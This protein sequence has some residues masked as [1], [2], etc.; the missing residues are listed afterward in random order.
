MSKYY[1]NKR[2]LLSVSSCGI[3]KK[4]EL[5]DLKFSGNKLMETNYFSSNIL[6]EI[7]T[8]MNYFLHTFKSS[9]GSHTAA[10]FNKKNEFLSL[11]EDIGRYNAVD[12][13]IGDL[14]IKDYI[15]QTVDV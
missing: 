12:K 14:I 9:G 5:K 6:H 1:L 15:K 8:K 3:C 11:K 2:T 4:K 10:I 7:L 13:V